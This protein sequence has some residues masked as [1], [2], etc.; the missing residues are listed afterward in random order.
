MLP[1]AI[2][3]AIAM[4]IG[5]RLTDRVGA[6]IPFTLG[7]AIMF[8]AYWPLAH[9]RP[10]TDLRWISLALLVAGL[11][12]GL[13]MMAPNIVAMNAVT[14]PQVGQASGLSQVTRQISAAFG[15]AVLASIFA[16]ALPADVGDR[17]SS[18]DPG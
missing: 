2:G 10:D 14:A 7:A 17:P 9:L 13:G 5:G 18:V 15:T 11:G 1:A 16:S 4:P 8:A 6:R 12:A 3:V